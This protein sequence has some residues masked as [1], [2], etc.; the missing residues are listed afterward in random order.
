M[1]Y[2][3]KFQNYEY[4][5]I[6]CIGDSTTCQDWC[7]PNWISWLSYTFHQS[8]NWENSYK[9]LII[10]GGIDGADVKEVLENFEF[11]IIDAKPDVIILSLGLNQLLP[12]FNKD[13]AFCDLDLLFSKINEQGIEIIAWSPYALLDQKFNNDLKV[14][15]KI[16]EVLCQRYNACYVDIFHAFLDND[17]TKLF[18]FTNN[19]NPEWGISENSIDFLHCN[20]LGN[21]IIAQEIA[22]KAFMTELLDWEYGNMKLTKLS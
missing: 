20:A 4:L 10:N 13:K 22:K 7:H 15:S 18:T 3:Q 8:D 16:Y 17:L 12:N 5:R 2:L 1:E 21:Q 6:V 19:E 14:L 11:F 9:R